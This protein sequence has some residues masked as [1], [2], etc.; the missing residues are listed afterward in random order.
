MPACEF[1]LQVSIW[2]LVREVGRSFMPNPAL[3]RVLSELGVS[4]NLVQLCDKYIDETLIGEGE[5]HIYKSKYSNNK[6]IFDLSRDPLGKV[7]I[8][9][10]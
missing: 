7:C 4:A 9:P 8:T 10:G 6:V 1:L 5:V 3:S 2:D